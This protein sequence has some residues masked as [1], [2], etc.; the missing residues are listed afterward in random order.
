MDL[1]SPNQARPDP[2]PAL[3]QGPRPLAL[4]LAN[5]SLTWMTS[6]AA[7]PLLKRLAALETG[8]GGKGKRAAAKPRRR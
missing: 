7:L 6:Q 4:H 5:A 2:A 3:R 1:A 8:T